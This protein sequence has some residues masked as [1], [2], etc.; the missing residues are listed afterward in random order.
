[1]PGCPRARWP[2][3]SDPVGRMQATRSRPAGC[4]WERTNSDVQGF[5]DPL[6]AAYPGPVGEGLRVAVLGAGGAARGVVAALTSRG[7]RVT[8]HARRREQAAEVAVDSGAGI[9]PWPPPA[10]SWDLLVNCP[11]LG[12]ASARGETPLPGGP[13]DGRLV[14]DLTYGDTAT[15]LVREAGRSGCLTID[16]LPML[17]AQ[18]ERQFEWWTGARPQPGIMAAAAAARTRRV[19]EM[20]V[21]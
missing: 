4:T 12:G 2:R 9:G 7:A 8:V 11:P 19:R 1:M 5:L 18:A 13:F 14:Y 6:E 17:V 20:S 21:R 16:G 10:G 15:P 3:G